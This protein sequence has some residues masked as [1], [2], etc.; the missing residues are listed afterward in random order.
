M[1]SPQHGAPCQAKPSG[2]EVAGRQ[3]RDDSDYAVD[4][5][6]RC[7][8]EFDAEIKD[9]DRQLTRLVEATAPRLAALAIFVC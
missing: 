5:V 3:R 1:R 9:L 7:F 8:R 6:T 2:S 4:T